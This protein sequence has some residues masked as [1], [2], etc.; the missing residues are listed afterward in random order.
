MDEL[1]KEKEVASLESEVIVAP[2]G[3][4]TESSAKTETGV[5]KESQESFHSE[6]E[7]KKMQEQSLEE[8][9]PD[10]SSVETIPHKPEPKKAKGKKVAVIA[11]IAALAIAL[12]A[13]IAS[14]SGLKR[15]IT[16]LDSENAKIQKELDEAND[17]NKELEKQVDTLNEKID[18]LENGASAQLV[19]IKNAYDSGEWEKV[20]NLAADLH[21]AYNGSAEDIEAQ[22][23]AAEAQGK[24]DEANAAKAAEEAKGYE[25]GITYDQ[26]ARTPDDYKGSKVKFSGKVVQV[27]EGDG[28]VQLRLAVN[29]SYDNILFLEYDSSLVKSRVLEDDQITIYGISA[30][31]ITYQSTMGGNI[32]IPAVLVQKIDQ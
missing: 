1:E 30:G 25:T 19:A 28:K 7:E 16:D 12:I 32:T 11:A 15:Q 13:M 27:I 20:V 14:N 4:S 9:V 8:N 29:N 23:L 2:L 6:S 10:N 17:T 18:E 21:N 5:I 26:L 22:Q 3:E 31:T 24:I